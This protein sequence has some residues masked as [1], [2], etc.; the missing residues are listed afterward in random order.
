VTI[1][2]IEACLCPETLGYLAKDIYIMLNIW[3]GI[4]LGP[5]DLLL[6]KIFK[7][8]KSLQQAF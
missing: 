5:V 7:E 4:I 2:L 8:R 6:I 1:C 3:M